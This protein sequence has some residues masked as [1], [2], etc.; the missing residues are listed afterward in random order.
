MP[1]Q[2]TPEPH[3]L[4]IVL[5]GDLTRAELRAALQDLVVWESASTVVPH[6]LTDLRLVKSSELKADDIIAAAEARKAQRFRNPFRSAI[7]ASDPARYGYARM[8][9]IM[10]T[11]P[12]IT[13][14]VFADEAAAIKWLAPSA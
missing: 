10:N 14:E 4:R 2:I 9:Q 1:Y 8:F 7:V 13:V 11:H 12:D 5:S 3:F 6:R